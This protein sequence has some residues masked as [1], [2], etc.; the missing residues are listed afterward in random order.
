MDGHGSHVKARLIDFCL[1]HSIDLM[2]LPS[3][4]SHITQPLDDGIFGPLKAAMARAIDQAATYDCGRIS[5]ADWAS[6]LAAARTTA[7]IEHNIR[8]GW[9]ATGLHPFNPQRVLTTVP[10][11]PTPL[12]RT[13]LA[14]L[15]SEI[16]DFMQSCSPSMPTP[17][18]NRITSLVSAVEAVNARNTVL[19]RENQGLRDASE[20]R[21]RKRAVVTVGNLGTH[22]FST[23]DCLEQ[24]RAAEAA[25]KAR[26]GKGKEREVPV[27]SPGLLEDIRTVPGAMEWDLHDTVTLGD[28]Y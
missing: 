23:E 25:T 5:K 18:K 12:P 6:T 13:P 17:V 16:L 9:K 24:V 11:T 19:E 2:V 10:P 4:T 26:K 15:T 8:V 3:H 27:G 14:S 21:K 22:V 20:A 7:M 28:E 1:N